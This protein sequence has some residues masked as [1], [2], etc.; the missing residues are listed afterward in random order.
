[1][2]FL[3]AVMDIVRLLP[4]TSLALASVRI[5]ET[6]SPP[7]RTQRK[8]TD[9]PEQDLAARV[10]DLE[11]RLAYHDDRRQ[12]SDLYQR[13]MRGFDRN[14]V[15][16]LRSA[17]WPDVQINYSEQVNTFDQFVER[18]LDNHTGGLTAWGHLLTNETVAIDGDTAHVETYVTALFVPNETSGF[19]DRDDNRPLIVGG[20]YVDRVDRRDGEWRIAVREFVAHFSSRD[21]A[22]DSMLRGMHREHAWDRQDVSYWRPLLRREERSAG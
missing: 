13:Y 12:I 14:D 16:L 6:R 1:M 7:T 18:H 10:A 2:D 15:E 22:R 19:G 17:F 4:R 8:D 21:H 9:V 20:R 3:P 5:P 11:A